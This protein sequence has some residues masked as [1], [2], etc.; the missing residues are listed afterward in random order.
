MTVR[1]ILT[2]KGRD[3]VTITPDASLAEAAKVMSKQR[4]GALVITGA[5]RRVVGILSE[6]DVVGAVAARGPSALEESVGNAMTR[7]VVT[8][9]ED[10]T[11]PDLMQRMTAGRFRHVPVV[12]RGQLAGIVSIGDVV[13][14]RLAEMERE[15]EALR[16]YIATA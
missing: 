12:N 16:E 10:E 13:K 6:R 14:F 9:T 1:A 8:C 15:Q 7:E 4:I 11:V 5:E 3:C 2:L